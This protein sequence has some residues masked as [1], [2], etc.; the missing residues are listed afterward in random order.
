MDLIRF[1]VWIVLFVLPRAVQRALKGP[2]ERLRFKTG[3]PVLDTCKGGYQRKRSWM[4]PRVAWI[5]P[6]QKGPANVLWM[7]VWETSQGVRT[8]SAQQQLH[9]QNHNHCVNY[10][11]LDILK[12]VATAVASSKSIC[13]SKGNATASL[14][15]GS[16]HDSIMNGTAIS[17]LGISLSNGNVHEPNAADPGEGKPQPQKTG[18][19]SSSPSQESETDSPSSSCSLE[20]TMGG[21]VTGNI[22]KNAGGANLLFG[23]SDTM[24][25]NV[26]LY[27][28]H[29]RHL[30]EHPLFNLHQICVNRHQVHQSVPVNH[31][32]SHHPSRRKSDNKASTYGMNYLLSNCTNGN[33]ANT[34]TPWKTRKY[35]PGVLGWVAQHRNVKCFRTFVFYVWR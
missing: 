1:N 19:L 7:H 35:N 21:N 26:N 10:A 24:E 22:N 31:A 30:Q 34:W 3:S 8:L 12:N 4:D 33:N 16:S 20:R 9:N 2:T 18:S 11:A 32:H 5:Q 29:H 6:E 13:S 27:H 17:S 14:R 23:V 15:N 25:N 28:H